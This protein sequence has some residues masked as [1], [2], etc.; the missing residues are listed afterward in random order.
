MEIGDEGEESDKSGSFIQFARNILSMCGELFTRLISTCPPSKKPLSAG[1][2]CGMSYSY[3]DI[4]DDDEA[5]KSKR[6]LTSYSM[7]L[8]GSQET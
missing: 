5:E 7:S 3:A 4:M 6:G 2:I 1:D 8:K